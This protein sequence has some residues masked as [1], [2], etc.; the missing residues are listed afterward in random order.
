[1]RRVV[2]SILA[3]TIVAG[4]STWVAAQ[5]P[6]TLST[7]TV[8]PTL[9]ASRAKLPEL[10]IPAVCGM[11]LKGNYSGPK[12]LDAI[13]A[14]GI[15]VVRRGFHWDS[16]EKT[17]G[18]YDFTA[19]DEV[20]KGLRERGLRVVGCLAFGNKLYGPVRQDEGRAAYARYAAALAE[21]YKADR[22]MWEIWNE[23]NTMTFWGRHGKKGNSEPYAEEYV[24]L[25]KATVPA[26]RQAD[27]GCVI[28][29]GSVSCLWSESYK[30]T[31]FCFAK[32]VLKTGIDAWSVHP[33]SPNMPEDYVAAYDKVRDMM[34]K[35]GASRDFPMLNTERGFGTSTKGEGATEGKDSMKLHYQAWLLVRQQLID[36]SYGMHL[37]S[38]YEWKNAKESF[39]IYNGDKPNRACK[40]YEAMIAQLRGYRFSKRVATA[41]PQD[42]V[43]AFSGPGNA[44]KLVAWTSPT[45]GGLDKTEPHAIELPVEATGK[46]AVASIYGEQSS[47]AVADG[48]IAITLGGAPQYIT[49]RPGQ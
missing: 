49:V 8:K 10:S 12:D 26:M 14:V 44:L 20:M 29:A 45:K 35:H 27:P 9:A 47:L 32:G 15:Q 16:I 2:V 42:F 46:V 41:S 4:M 33:Y 1:M 13:K 6:G 22:V 17:K 3:W 19:H 31:D 43:L 36:L 11:Q 7:S 28:L 24:T 38:W 34:A 25:V 23:P 18:V 39:G 40:A 48:R 37:T 5:Q 30:W 21:H